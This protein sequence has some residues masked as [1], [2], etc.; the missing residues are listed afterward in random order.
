MGKA[1]AGRVRNIEALNFAA[2]IP[3]EVPM[4]GE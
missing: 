4:L 2:I 3:R 1:T